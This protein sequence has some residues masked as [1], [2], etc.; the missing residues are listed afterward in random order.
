MSTTTNDRVMRHSG[1]P[2]LRVV[3]AL[4]LIA[5]L[6]LG[7]LLWF[8]EPLRKNVMQF[9][10]KEA[11][12]THALMEER[13][14]KRIEEERKRRERT[15]IK[16][17]DS[18][19]LK[20]KA[21][22]KEEEK[23]RRKLDQMREI[24]E[25]IKQ[26][27]RDA[28][29][30]LKMRTLNHLNSP[31]A[32]DLLS[33]I[34]V[35]M[36]NASALRN[37]TKVPLAGEVHTSCAQL[38]RE[39][40]IFVNASTPAQHA[41]LLLQALSIRTALQPAVDKAEA[42][43]QTHSEEQT[44]E[45]LGLF[46]YDAH[47]VL[48]TL[49]DY[50]KRLQEYSFDEQDLAPFNE[51]P[52]IAK[53]FEE[54]DPLPLDKMSLE[55]M[56]LE[57]DRLRTEITQDFKELRAAEIANIEHSSF[58][59][60]LANVIAATASQNASATQFHTG[61]QQAHSQSTDA[62]ENQTG[63]QLG[64]Q[65]SSHSQ[66]GGQQ[67]ATG[68]TPRGTQTETVGDL[69]RHRQQ[70]AGL[71]RHVTQRWM[72]VQNMAQQANSESGTRAADAFKSGGS[73]RGSSAS[74]SAG[75]NGGAGRSKYSENR[76]GTAT[77]FIDPRVKARSKQKELGVSVPLH[78]IQ[79]KALPGRRFQKESQRRGWLFIDT[80]YIIG[81]WEN[82]G[83]LDYSVKHPPEI[84]VDLGKEYADGKFRDWRTKVDRYP[85]K[86]TFTQSDI[87]RITPPNEAGHSTY[88]AFTEVHCDT[89]IDMY[90]AVG[91]DDAARLWL[92]DKLVWEDHGLSGWNL[93]EGFQLV[94]FNA[95]F[96]KLLLRI[97]NSPILCEFSVLL[98]P[99]SQIP[100]R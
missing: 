67:Q 82:D 93:G 11:Q 85:L 8:C 23:T 37:R 52:E 71:T 73:N 97:E 44:T 3:L 30:A 54:E 35:V 58:D 18:E 98:C 2:R 28:L 26:E 21:R 94:R 20:R 64:Q 87:M 9:N 53:S 6:A 79:A 15:E 48:R 59:E 91:T 50:L 76:T 24:K 5:Q 74:T 78:E 10:P 92:N 100:R 22:R 81:P 69:N 84:E 56:V 39:T 51:I 80:W 49:D 66:Q 83:K 75:G 46:L 42:Y 57:S 77:A 36:M 89:D 29:N 31:V 72:A 96:N 34:N 45:K 19:A 70:L 7:A 38:Q 41:A 55:E 13:N 1:R 86:W 61:A 32:N 27:K 14:R 90:V 60:A 63:A 65:P 40:A 17:A 25:R 88:Y 16:K 33:L 47:G 62:S 4:S 43:K 68:S 99:P 95:G 12:E